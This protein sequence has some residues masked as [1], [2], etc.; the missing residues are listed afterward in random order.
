[1]TIPEL[2]ERLQRMTEKKEVYSRQHDELFMH[3]L[4]AQ[5]EHHAGVGTEMFDLEEEIASLEQSI[6]ELEEDVR[7]S[8]Q[9]FR[10]EEQNRDGS[11]LSF[12]KR[13]VAVA[14]EPEDGAR[15]QTTYLKG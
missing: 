13:I 1:M 10:K 9:G 11:H 5:A 12:R 15:I 2:E 4:L 6:L 7:E 3:E 8:H 14:P